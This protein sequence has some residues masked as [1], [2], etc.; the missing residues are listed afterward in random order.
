MGLVPILH[1]SDVQFELNIINNDSKDMK[2][3]NYL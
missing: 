2:I 1:W 3:L